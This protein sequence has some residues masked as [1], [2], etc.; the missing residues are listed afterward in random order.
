[1]LE[2]C[3]R[4]HVHTHTHKSTEMGPT[5]NWVV[6][7]HQIIT[8]FEIIYLLTSDSYLPP[9][10][11]KWLE[12]C[13]ASFRCLLPGLLPC[14]IIL[15]PHNPHCGGTSWEMAIATWRP[16]TGPLGD[17]KQQQ[18]WLLNNTIRFNH[19]AG[20]IGGQEI[21]GLGCTAWTEVPCYELS[22]FLS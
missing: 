13:W 18:Q 22:C 12:S 16:L 21:Y 10:W 4:H 19:K 11:V 6:G 17:L 3:M 20:N 5:C 15:S 2:V 14:L 1:M 9:K 8:H 7:C